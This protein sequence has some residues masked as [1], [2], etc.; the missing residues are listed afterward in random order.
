MGTGASTEYGSIAEAIA[1]GLTEAEI[2]DY[3]RKKPVQ[4][5]ASTTSQSLDYEPVD[6]DDAEAALGIVV[7]SS[8]SPSSSPKER[9]PRSNDV[10]VS[11][12][13]S[14]TDHQRETLSEGVSSFLPPRVRD[15][16]ARSEETG[17]KLTVP[18]KGCVTAC[19]AF[20]DMCGFTKLLFEMKSWARWSK[21]PRYLQSYFQKLTNSADEH[22][23]DLYKFAGDLLIFYLVIDDSA[24]ARK[25]AA[26]QMVQWVQLALKEA[27]VCNDGVTLQMHAGVVIGKLQEILVGGGS[28]STGLDIPYDYVLC[29]DLLREQS[30]VC[31][32]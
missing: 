1:A 16:L 11:R 15:K 24:A 17:Q 5:T 19:V 7:T 25:L 4:P 9:S 10:M 14:V 28:T 13:I 31:C 3:L 26:C 2:D 30:K 6:L 21:W 32:C 8:T 22:G 29:G 12:R 18:Q 20:L 23:I 27:Q